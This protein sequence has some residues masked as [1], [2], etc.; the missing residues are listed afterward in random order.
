M[1][2]CEKKLLRS[3]ASVTDTKININKDENVH[4]Y[5]V[6]GEQIDKERDMQ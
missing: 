3:N 2:L 6:R 1:M 4:R 5:S